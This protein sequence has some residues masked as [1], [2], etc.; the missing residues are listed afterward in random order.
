M[1]KNVILNIARTELK[2]IFTTPVA[3]IMMIVFTVLCAL[4]FTDAFSR[5]AEAQAAGSHLSFLTQGMFSSDSMGLFPTVQFYLFLFI[6]LVSMGMISRDLSTGSIKLL[7]SSPVSDAQIVLGKFVA[8]LGYGL[9]MIAVVAMFAVFGCLMINNVDVPL[10]LTGIMGLFFLICAYSA[11]GVFMS[12]LTSYQVVAA[13]ATFAVLAVLSMVNELA[14]DIVWLRDITWWLSI[15]GRCETFIA[16]LICSEDVIYFITVTALFLVLAILRISNKRRSRSMKLRLAGYSAAVLVTVLVAFLSSRP[17]LMSFYDATATKMNTITRPSQEIMARV[18]GKVT[19]TT[20]T[21]ILDEEGF[22]LGIPSR[23]NSD[24]E[25]FKQYLRFKPDIKIKY[26][27]YWADAGSKSVY[28]RFPDMTNE[29]RAERIADI[30]EINFNK[31]QTLEE[32][33]KKKDLSG[34]KYRLV[35]EIKLEDGRS[36]FLRIFNDSKRMP[37]EKE[38]TATFK[39]LIDGAVPVAFLTGHGERNI[40]KPGDKDYLIF[41]S[42]KGQRHSL[43]NNG[44]D[45]VDIDLKADCHIPDSIQILV[46]ADPREEFAAE[47]LAEIQRYIDSGRNMIIAADP[48]SQQYA[49][50]V[51]ALVGGTFMPGRISVPESDL[52]QDLV[53]ARIMAEAAEIHP[54]MASLTSS[55]NKVTMQGAVWVKATDEKGF[56]PLKLFASADNSWNEIHTTDFAN[57]VASYDPSKGERQGAKTVA[58]QLTR[59]REDGTQKI[60]LM[61]DSDCF[62]NGELTRQRYGVMSSN[63]PLIYQ[64]FKWLCDGKYPI[65]TPRAGSRDAS[66]K[67]GIEMLPFIKWG[68]AA[69]LPLIMLIAAILIF[70]RRKSR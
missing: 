41:S 47:E 45:I 69:I 39:R 6:P 12:S 1:K 24:K 42:D 17:H 50:Q 2:M 27:Y 57:T 34:E 5:Y 65:D 59:P 68:F 33:S 19:M 54:Q 26:E 14:Q 11:I 28:R 10:V 7:Y 30:Y 8:M 32:I 9:T 29:Q 43:I 40:Y 22:Y 16:G 63:F 51:A 64:T 58:M 49:G 60:L 62:S 61:G 18:K 53:L 70:V 37:E 48:G 44:F 20:Y 21:N 23:F 13:L 46:I 52:Q 3:W 66:M 25:Y 4:F 15:S 38:I 67:A 56:T 55:G 36:T 35:R 31:F